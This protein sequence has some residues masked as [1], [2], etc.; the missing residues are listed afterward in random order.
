MQDYGK[1]LRI[2]RRHH[3]LT[4]KELADKLNVT[5]QTVSKWENGVNRIDICYLQDI[6]ALFSI[7]ID[8]FIH[9]ADG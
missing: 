1:A 6:T 8:Q 3:N 5:S 4:Q 7:T 9:I 2:L